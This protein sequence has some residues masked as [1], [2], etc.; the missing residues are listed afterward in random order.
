[1]ST[2]FN[3]TYRFLWVLFLCCLSAPALAQDATPA[4]DD[5]LRTNIE[6][7]QTDISVF[8]KNGKFVDS[9]KPEQFLLSVDG[10]KRPLS[11]ISRVTSGSSV[12]AEQLRAAR[13][14]PTLSNTPGS[15]PPTPVA[16]HGRVIFFFVDDVHLSLDGLTRGRK[17][18]LQFVNN[19]MRHDDQVAIVSTTGQ[20]GFLQQLTDNRVVLRAAIDRLDYKRRPDDY[21]GRTK[22]SEHTAS[23]VQDAHNGTLFAYLMDSVKVEYGMGLGALRGDHGNDSAGQARRL[24]QN[25][26]RSIGQQNR[27]D[28]TATL[29]ALRFLL[30][31]STSL[32][33]RKLIFFLSDGFVVDP[34]GS[35]ALEVLKQLSAIAAR[36]GAV[37]YSMDTRGTNIDSRVD[38]SRNE[39]ADMSSRQ[40]GMALGEAFAPREPLSLLAEDT[41]GRAIFNSNSIEDTVAQAVKETSEYYVLAWRPETEEER[42]GK[43]RIDVSI[44][45]R[46]DLRLRLRRQYFAGATTTT[47]DKIATATRS[48]PEVQLLVALG[49]TYPRR[50]L[51][52]S[53]S[54]GYL[55]NSQSEFTLQASMQI[56]RAAFN[57]A[58][59]D[60]QK[61]EVDV[62]GAAIDDR[63]FIYSFKQVLTVTPAAGEVDATSVVW[64]QQLKVQPGLYQVRVA[65]RE[66]QTGRSGSAIQWI[67]IPQ[68][69]QHRL[70]M[71]SLFLGERA[72][73]VESE[74]SRGPK[75]IRVDVDHRFER[76]SVLRF[77]TY[78][79]NPAH[80]P[81]GPDVWIDAQI[82]RGTEKVLV[83]APSKIPPDVSKDRALLPYWTEISLNELPSGHYTL[84]VSATDRITN[85]HTSQTIRFS[86]E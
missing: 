6:L 41:G 82:M 7:V 67:E 23:Q 26:I 20:I 10:R 57:L 73:E 18:L 9:L 68:P 13:G 50:D 65:V 49:S 44:E 5:V 48:A 19:Q 36:S 35:N 52:T 45:G 38:A 15:K 80:V 71:S 56:E 4:N 66:R 25:R 59:L 31:S 76:K 37:I 46:P 33:G 40:T 75:P 42:K 79:Y 34:R 62:I 83:L 69:D 17:A 30:Q 51:P 22:I 28:T 1:M 43:A 47:T 29:K 84:Q 39:F 77:Q 8:D 60:G 61:A 11:L 14:G 63:G 72:G 3:P 12:E 78:V 81:G 85:H 16:S 86:V 53:L 32:P 27:A 70:S 74:K 54:V 64:G 24:L 55:K 21:V 58:A 2:H